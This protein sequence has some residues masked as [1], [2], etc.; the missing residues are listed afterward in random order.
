M[1]NYARGID[2]EKTYKILN[3]AI[4]Y[5]RDNNVTDAET[6]KYV[7]QG[8]TETDNY[9][10]LGSYTPEAAQIIGGFTGGRDQITDK[11]LSWDDLTDNN[12][13]KDRHQYERF[14]KMILKLAFNTIESTYGCFLL[15][16]DRYRKE[17]ESIYNLVGSGMAKGRAN[18]IRGAI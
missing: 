5:A 13:S 2:S 9:A 6:G 1:R 16:V 8:K 15:I 11:I 17:D 12:L 3:G 18:T 7:K 4:K 10:E 14:N